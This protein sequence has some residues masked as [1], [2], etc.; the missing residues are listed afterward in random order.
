MARRAAWLWPALLVPAGIAYQYLVHSAVAGGQDHSVRV[1]LAFMPLL[2]LA[3]WIFARTHNKLRWSLIVAAAAVAL[4]ALETRVAWGLDAVYGLPHAAIYCSLLWLFGST[5]RADR[6]PLI[7]RFARRVHGTLPA[8]MVAYTR[9]A[10]YAWSVFFAAQL[11]I[12]ALLFRFAPLYWWSLFINVLNLPLLA[13]MFA[14]EYAYRTVKHRDFLHASL[15]DGIRAFTA[16]TA[17][18]NDITCAGP[19]P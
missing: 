6:E 2:A 15:L 16:D 11:I 12:S 18:R 3:G 13:L 5:L 8:G 14:G 1:A 17:Q 9:S 10:T 4:Y 7:T 19:R